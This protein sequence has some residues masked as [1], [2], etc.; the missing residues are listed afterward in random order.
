MKIYEDEKRQLVELA[1]NY[2]I[3]S[4]NLIKDDT[5]ENKK[6][7]ILLYTYL[8]GDYQFS[9]RSHFMDSAYIVD[10]SRILRTMIEVL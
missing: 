2:D 10:N 9:I 7:I 6:A 5:I 1:E 3:I 8:Y 4:K